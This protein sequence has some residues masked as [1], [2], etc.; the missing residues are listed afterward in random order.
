[1]LLN[2]VRMKVI[3]TILGHASLAV[4]AL[5]YTQVMPERKTSALESSGRMLTAQPTA[6]REAVVF[7]KPYSVRPAGVAEWQTQST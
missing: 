7:W 5:T 2:G 6:Q 4:T 1:M 3:Q